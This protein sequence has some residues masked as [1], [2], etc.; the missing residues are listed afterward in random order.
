MFPHRPLATVRLSG[1]AVGGGAIAS[2]AF[3]ARRAPCPLLVMMELP[4]PGTRSPMS[5]PAAKEPRSLSAAGVLAL[6]KRECSV[7]V[8]AR[9]R[10]HALSPFGAS[11]AIPGLNQAHYQR[12]Q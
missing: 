8:N 6:S 5:L 10:P 2:A 9:T 12:C 3:A 7:G 1:L 4:P 11:D